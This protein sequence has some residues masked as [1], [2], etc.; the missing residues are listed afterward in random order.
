MAISDSLVASM[1]NKYQYNFWRPEAAIRAA[2]TDGNPRTEQDLTYL[3]FIT[4]PC[5]PSYPSNHASGTSG[6]AEVLRRL[7]GPDGH[8][9]TL[10]NPA[11]PGITLQYTQFSEIA[12]DV[13]DA[14]VYGGIHYRFDQVTGGKLGRAVANAVYKNNLRQAQNAAAAET[15]LSQP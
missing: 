4:T 8:S 5:F 1:Y 12:A 14:R 7:Y 11:V 9:I 3:P 2:E 13:D 6:G 15:R 10:S